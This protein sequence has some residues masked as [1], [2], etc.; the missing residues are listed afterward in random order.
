MAWKHKKRHILVL[1]KEADISIKA[2][3]SHPCI[4]VSDGGSCGMRLGHVWGPM[5]MLYHHIYGKCN[6]KAL[7]VKMDTQ[8]GYCLLFQIISMYTIL[9]L[10]LFGRGRRARASMALLFTL[11]EWGW[12][13]KI[14]KFSEYCNLGPCAES[15]M[16]HI[17]SHCMLK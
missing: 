3:L 1:K 9:D 5:L 16:P 15:V 2:G 13:N 10:H 6:G 14:L 12:R 17:F 7:N 4:M 8:T 11:G